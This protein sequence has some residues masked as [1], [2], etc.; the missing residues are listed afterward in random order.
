MNY[1]GG[2][3]SVTIDYNPQE[4]EDKS[5]ERASNV[6][7]NR[8][9]S[10]TPGANGGNILKEYADNMEFPEQDEEL[11]PGENDSNA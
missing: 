6:K 8:F 1:E 9:A 5:P 11:R 3:S 7:M 2:E 10:V 4:E